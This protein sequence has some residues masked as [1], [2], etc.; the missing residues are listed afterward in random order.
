MRILLTGASGMVGQ[1][2]QSHKSFLDYEWL[3]PSSKSLNLLNYSSVSDYV[4][5]HKPD[6]V[7]HAAGRVGGIQ[8]NIREGS[9]F[10]VENLDMGRNVLLASAQ[11]GVPRLLN[12]AS[13]CIYPKDRDGSLSE[14]DV[15]T[16]PLEPTNEG[17]A[18]AKIA[19]L[20]LASLI[21]KESKHLSYKTLIPSNLYGPY[22]NFDPSW[23]HMIPSIISK[24]HAAKVGAQ[25]SVEIWGDGEARREFLFV[26]DLAKAI[27]RAITYF[28][29]LPSLMNVGLGI[30][31]SVNEYYKAAARVIGFEGSFTYNLNMPTGMRR[32]LSDIAL[33]RSWGW[34]PTHTLE[35]GLALTYEFYINKANLGC[36]GLA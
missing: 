32:K 14:N 6:M 16:G 19:V 9:R 29:S 28:D 10:L 8:A 22:D 20:R 5:S 36:R 4:R 12:L 17:Y 31:Y 3:T 13:S 21:S 7:I 33:A 15:L 11:V 35:S 26:D 27:Y 1:S 34:S 2:V 25:E 24:I 30:D 18:L 23:S